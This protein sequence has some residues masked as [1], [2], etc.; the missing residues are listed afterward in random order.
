MFAGSVGPTGK[1]TGID[2]SDAML[3]RARRSAAEAGADNVEFKRADAEQL[4]LLD[5]SIDVALVNGIFNL[6]PSR[7]AIFRE[8]AR[9]VRIDGCV[10]GAELVLKEPLPSDV[11]ADPANWFA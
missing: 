2:F 7:D 8:L 4:P 10:F 11:H 1:V 9:V 3:A 6:N 5:A